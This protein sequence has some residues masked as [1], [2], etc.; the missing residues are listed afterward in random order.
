LFCSSRLFRPTRSALSFQS[1]STLPALPALLCLC[2]CSVS[3]APLPTLYLFDLALPVLFL[4]C[5]VL[6]LRWYTTPYLFDL[7]CACYVVMLCYATLQLCCTELRCDV[8]ML[9]C[10]MLFDV[11]YVSYAYA[12]LRLCRNELWWMLTATPWL[13]MSVAMLCYACAITAIT[14]ARRC[15]CRHAC[16]VR[17]AYAMLLC[18]LQS[19]GCLILRYAM[20][21]YSQ[22]VYAQAPLM[23]V[24]W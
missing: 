21:G 1:C 12:M 17:Y 8:A 10:A 16:H 9:H 20:P 3:P 22:A 14:V 23:S 11:C 13:A 15:T 4:Y 7:C 18:P 24:L 2:L 6:V 5:S 19:S